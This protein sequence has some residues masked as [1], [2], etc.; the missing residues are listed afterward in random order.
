VHNNCVIVV[1]HSIDLGWNSRVGT[2]H[3]DLILVQHHYNN[4]TTILHMRVSPSTW[5]S[6]SCEGLLYSC[7]IG[8]V[9][10]TFSPTIWYTPMSLRLCTTITQLFSQSHFP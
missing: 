3:R 6:P 2:H 9:N 5:D 10:L 4:C 8:V 1:H 7:C